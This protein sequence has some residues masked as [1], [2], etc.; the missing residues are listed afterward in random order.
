[1]GFTGC[2]LAAMGFAGYGLA[3]M[4]QCVFIAGY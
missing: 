3:A 4:Q 2:G 1:M